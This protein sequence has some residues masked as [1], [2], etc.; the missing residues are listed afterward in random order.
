M[1]NIVE[2]VF[3]QAAGILD[4][5]HTV[6]ERCARELLAKETLDEMAIRALTTDLRRNIQSRSGTTESWAITLY[7]CAVQHFAIR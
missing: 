7:W 5:H 2:A 4:A 1:R 6:L 3:V